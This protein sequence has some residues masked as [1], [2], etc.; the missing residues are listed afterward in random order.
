MKEYLINSFYWEETDVL[1][2]SICQV[3]NICFQVSFW[4]VAN[5]ADII[6]F[7]NFSLR[8]KDQRSG[9]KSVFGFF[10]NLVLKGIMAFWS[11]RVHE[12]YWQN[13]K[14]KISQA[15][16]ERRILCFSSYKN[17][18]LKV[19]LDELELAKKND[20]IFCNVFFVR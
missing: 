7:Y 17:C 18:K 10:V 16:L 8:L 14:W 11:Q 6:K 13:R 1:Q 2:T 4:K 20:L 9:S 3:W 19:K 12:F 15:V 5:H